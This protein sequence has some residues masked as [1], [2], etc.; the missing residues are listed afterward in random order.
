MY[1]ENVSDVFE[2]HLICYH[3]Y[4]DDMQAVSHGHSLPSDPPAQNCK[5]ESLMSVPGVLAKGRS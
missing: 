2:S 1:Y 3:L 4:A 5:V